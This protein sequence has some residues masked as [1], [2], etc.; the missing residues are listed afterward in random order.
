[1]LYKHFT[2][3]GDSTALVDVTGE[4]TYAKLFKAVV[5]YSQTLKKI[6]V[7]EGS[8]VGLWSYNSVNFL[9]AF[10]A[11]LE[12][13]ATVVLIN[14]STSVTDAAK[15]AQK[16]DCQFL[17]Y[18]DNRAVKEHTNA[19]DEF[20]VLSGIDKENILSIRNEDIN[21]RKTDYSLP[22]NIGFWN[23]T[24]KTCDI[25]IFTT[26]TTANAKAVMSSQEVYID[27]SDGVAEFYGDMRKK[28]CLSAPFFHSL[29]LYYSTTYLYFGGCVYIPY[30]FS[31]EE[32]YKYIF[33]YRV[34]H[35][36]SVATVYLKMTELESFKY[37][38]PDFLKLCIAGGGA[39]TPNQFIQIEKTFGGAKFMNGY[40]ATEASPC[41][42]FQ[43]PRY[44]IDIRANSVGKPA[45]GKHLEIHDKD[46][47]FLPPGEIGEVFIKDD[48]NV[49]L[50]YYNYEDPEQYIDEEG[51]LHTGDLGY[52]DAEGFVHL[53]G[54]SK[55]IIIKGGE[56]IAP[57]EIEIAISDSEQVLEA[58][59]FG[60]PHETLGESIE[61]CV[62]VKDR[63]KFSESKLMEEIKEKLAVFKLPSDIFVFDSFPLNGNGKPDMRKLRENMLSLLNRKKVEKELSG[64]ISILQ[65]R[66]RALQFS[67]TPVK[68]AFSSLLANLGYSKNNK[69]KILSCIEEFLNSRLLSNDNKLSAVDI[70]ATLKQNYMEV[71]IRESIKF[72]EPQTYTE[73]HFVRFADS[74]TCI[75]DEKFRQIYLLKFNYDKGFNVMSIFF[76]G[77]KI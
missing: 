51:W 9:I 59:V 45:R 64:G 6:G 61:A 77:E 40:G 57:R 1:M 37:H 3:I 74:Y 2:E 15:L 76:K 68:E 50:G 28:V 5:G 19:I 52:F 13:K 18:G 41:I 39:V 33:K 35:M 69:R 49:M 21:F 34:E 16:A 20:S 48:G 63:Q 38:K 56:N 70:M 4:Y 43:S 26:G 66:V 22:E 30:T 71:R 73:E 24:E 60:A 31:A 32:L 11:I 14:Y 12:A 67:F 27:D 54:R 23:K 10:F 75:L 42:T 72:L 17:L 62:R 29:G 58:K 25:I 36:V 53:V 65:M 8:R 47:G 55:D 46:A 44:S 7:K